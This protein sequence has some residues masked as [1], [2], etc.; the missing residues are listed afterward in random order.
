MDGFAAV[1]N[2]LAQIVGYPGVEVHQHL[3]E[4]VER[5][6]AQIEII[7]VGKEIALQPGGVSQGDILQEGEGVVVVGGRLTELFRRG[8]VAAFQ[9]AENLG[10]GIA[11]RDGDRGLLAGGGTLAHVVDDGAVVHVGIERIGARGNFLFRPGERRKEPK[12]EFILDNAL[13]GQGVHHI[14]EAF[15]LGDGDNSRAL[16]LVER[17]HVVC[18]HPAHPGQQGGH[19]DDKQNIQNHPEQGKAPAAS[20][21]PALLLPV[22]LDTLSASGVGPLFSLLWHGNNS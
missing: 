8:D 21:G 2:L 3:V 4:D 14:A 7:G 1:Q 12:G 19:A 5:V 18:Q 15:P 20:A 16:L 10:H 9:Q 17:Q 6:L 11:L 13:L 22:P